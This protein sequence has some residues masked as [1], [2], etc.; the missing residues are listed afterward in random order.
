MALS[1][2][3]LERE[4]VGIDLNVVKKRKAGPMSCSVDQSICCSDAFGNGDGRRLD[5]TV[6]FCSRE[7]VKL[8]YNIAPSPHL[9]DIIVSFLW[10][11]HCSTQSITFCPQR[12]AGRPLGYRLL[13][14][15]RLLSR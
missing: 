3:D 4:R 9:L 2:I 11:R 7:S 8:V 12:Q 13:P 10:S 14:S 15:L 6:S 1:T 5:I